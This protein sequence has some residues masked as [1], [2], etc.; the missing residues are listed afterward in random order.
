M[1]CLDLYRD[2]DISTLAAMAAPAKVNLLATAPER[3]FW[4]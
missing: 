1:Y 4:H 3:I 2:F